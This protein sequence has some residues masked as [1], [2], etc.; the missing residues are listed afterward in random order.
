[1]FFLVL[2]LF[3]FCEC[4]LNVCGEVESRLSVVLSS[5][6]LSLSTRREPYC[7]RANKGTRVVQEKE[8]AVL[9]VLS[10]SKRSTSEVDV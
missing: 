4:E 1:M 8:N 6:N 9:I 10:S 3:V 5:S 2:F 7:R